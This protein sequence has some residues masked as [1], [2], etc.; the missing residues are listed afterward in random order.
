MFLGVQLAGFFPVMSGMEM[1]TMR[2]VRV[3]CRLLVVFRS[4]VMR[5]LAVMLRRDLVV[6]RSFFVVFRY[7]ISVFHGRSPC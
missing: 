6:V 3:V 4:V 1:V 2:S 7:L 5:G